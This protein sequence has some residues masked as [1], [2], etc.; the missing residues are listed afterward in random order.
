MIV[1]LS[2]FG[3]RPNKPET[4]YGYIQTDKR[5]NV[6]SFLEKPSLRDAEK[7]IKN[8]NIFWNSGMFCFKTNEFLEISKKINFLIS[9]N[10]WKRILNYPKKEKV[11]LRRYLIFLISLIIKLKYISIDYAIIEKYQ[12]LMNIPLIIKWSDVGSLISYTDLIKK[13]RYKNNSIGDNL[14]LNSSNTS[15]IS[16]DKPIVSYGVKI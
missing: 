2:F 4:G 8:K 11:Q 1:K 14:I 10:Y 16:H 12:S 7:L 3:I 5:N 9:I 6:L 15:I 13:D